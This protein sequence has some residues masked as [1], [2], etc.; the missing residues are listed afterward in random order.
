MFQQ[1]MRRSVE[2]STPGLLSSQ[3]GSSQ[4]GWRIFT[5]FAERTLQNLVLFGDTFAQAC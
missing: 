1:T 4:E 2:A 3:S 5:P